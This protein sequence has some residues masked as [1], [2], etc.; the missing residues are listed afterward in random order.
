MKSKIH[1]NR[2]LA[3]ITVSKKLIHLST[4]VILLLLSSFTLK[5]SPDWKLTDKSSVWFTGKH[6]SGFFHNIKGEVTFDE[7]KISTARIN[8]E[9]EVKSI[10]TGNSLRTWNSKK[11]KWFDAKQFPTIT[12]IS[13]KFKKESKGYSVTGKLKMKGV[14]KQITIPFA[15]SDKTFSGSFPVRRSEF[16]VGKL[17]GLGKMVSDTIMVNFTIQVTK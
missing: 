8:L 11:K 7:N 12:F 4:L 15:F 14:E 16:K 5:D 1:E 6:I 3:L 10:K 13:E 9:A 17:K 2:K